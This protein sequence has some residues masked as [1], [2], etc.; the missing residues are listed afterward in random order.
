ME[1]IYSTLTIAGES[2]TITCIWQRFKGR[3]KSRKALQWKKEKAR[4]VTQLEVVSVQ[5]LEEG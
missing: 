5:R 4:G 1:V 3:Q 2:A